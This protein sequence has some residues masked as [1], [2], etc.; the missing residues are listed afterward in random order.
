MY[1][2]TRYDMVIRIRRDGKTELYILRAQVAVI[3]AAKIIAPMGVSVV[4]YIAYTIPYCA[5]PRYHLAKKT[6]SCTILHTIYR[7][8]WFFNSASLTYK[9]LTRRTYITLSIGILFR[10]RLLPVIDYS[11]TF[12][13][14][15]DLQ[16]G[17][18]GDHPPPPRFFDLPSIFSLSLKN[19]EK[20]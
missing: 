16:G 14:V 19:G 15:A 12:N 18:T 17:G 20:S 9:N 13:T 8:Q 2:G 5:A 11:Q 10:F 7:Y 4:P 3:R 1:N 6:K